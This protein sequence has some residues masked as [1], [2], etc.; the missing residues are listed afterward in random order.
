MNVPVLLNAPCVVPAAR[1]RDTAVRWRRRL[2]PANTGSRLDVWRIVRGASPSSCLAAVWR[3]PRPRPLDLPVEPRG[4]S[5]HLRRSPECPPRVSP[6]LEDPLPWTPG[7][8]WTILPSRATVT[9]RR[10]TPPEDLGHPCE[11]L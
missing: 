9:R 8:N 5:P 7:A 1:G 6:P 11:S 10:I 4:R 2:V 3:L